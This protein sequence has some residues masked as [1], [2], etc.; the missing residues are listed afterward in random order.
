MGPNLTLINICAAGSSLAYG[1]ALVTM[2][3]EGSLAVLTIPTQ[4]DVR[5]QLTLIHIQTGLHIFRRHESIEAETLVLSWDV[6]TLASITDVWTVL[7]LINVS[8]GPE[9]WHQG[10]SRATAALIAPL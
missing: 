5:V 9:V 8:A 7:T 2:A 6:G 3:D 4:T 10:V 1:V